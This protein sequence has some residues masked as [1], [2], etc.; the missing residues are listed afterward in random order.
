MKD[1]EMT[2][3]EPFRKELSGEEQEAVAGGMYNNL[4][5]FGE[6]D[7][8]KWYKLSDTEYIFRVSKVYEPVLTGGSIR[9]PAALLDRF[10]YNGTEAW[11]CGTVTESGVLY[12]EIPR[13]ATVHDDKIYPS[14]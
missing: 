3:N 1:M 13:P 12:S 5:Y 7:V 2:P 9:V 11:Y 14:S 6:G 4:S 8:G 10:R